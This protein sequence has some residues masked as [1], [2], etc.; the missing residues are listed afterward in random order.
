MNGERIRGVIF[1]DYALYKLTF[2]LHLRVA[3]LDSADDIAVVNTSLTRMHELTTSVENLHVGLRFGC[4][5][6]RNSF[7]YNTIQYNTIQ[8]NTIQYNTIQ[9]NLLRALHVN[10]QANPE[11]CLINSCLITDTSPAPQ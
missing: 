5:A 2:T 9:I 3:D 1:C 10:S 4:D 7:K 6:I 8:Y 11:R